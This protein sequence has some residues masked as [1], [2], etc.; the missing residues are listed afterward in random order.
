MIRKRPIKAKLLVVRRVAVH[1]RIGAAN[2]EDG[3]ENRQAAQPRVNGAEDQD[4]EKE[5]DAPQPK[6]Q[7]EPAEFAGQHIEDP[8]RRRQH[9]L[10]GPLPLDPR[11]DREGGLDI[12]GLHGGGH[13]QPRS[14]KRQVGEAVDRAYRAPR[15][16]AA[17]PEPHGSH[18]E[19]GRHERH[20]HRALPRAPID[21]QVVFEDPKSA[22]HRQLI[23][24]SSS[25]R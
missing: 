25:G 12:A 10:I 16:Q 11:H 5:R 4:H 19:D 8:Q 20:E 23:I 2:G 1:A 9:A 7:G 3:N 15:D 13:E 18:E 17:E 24:R 22:G 14:E 21:D 6:A